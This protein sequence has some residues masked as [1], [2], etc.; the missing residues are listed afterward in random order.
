MKKGH[1]DYGISIMN[2]SEFGM[3]ADRLDHLLTHAPL[4]T[5]ILMEDIDAAVHS[6]TK[7]NTDMLQSRGYY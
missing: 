6:R 4:Q 2:L 7:S 3:T 5:I 1:L